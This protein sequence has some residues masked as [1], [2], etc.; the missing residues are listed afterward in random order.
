MLT[1]G[2]WWIP[3]RSSRNHRQP[4][5]LSYIRQRSPDLMKDQTASED[6][7]VRYLLGQLPEDERQ[8][9]ERRAFDDDDYYRQIL[10]VEDDLRVAYAQGT[11]TLAER[12]QFEKRFLIFADERKRVELAREMI[13]EL[14]QASAQTARRWLSW[15]FGLPRLA[16][17]AMRFAMGTA[18]FLL[19]AGLVWLLFDRARLRDQLG[20][21]QAERAAVEERIEGRSIEERARLEQLSR[22]LEEERERRARLE[23]ELGARQPALASPRPSVV[24][25]L[26]TPGLLRGGGETKRL[27]LPQGATQAQLRLEVSGGDHSS[28]RA[29]ILNADGKEIWSRAGLR[30]QGDG[31][32]RA[33]ILNI[34]ARLLAEDDYELKLMGLGRAGE[35]ERIGSYYYTVLKER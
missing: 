32:R 24:A 15:P 5:R 10:E 19:V 33:V 30:A 22:Q 6:I 35:P 12:E 13:A 17:P 11:L 3:S 2:V 16:S 21:L 29:V 31:A 8:G 7:I 26:L 20:R 1:S 9:I 27:V 34:P 4:E 28:F 18:A 25:L 23:Q 14:P